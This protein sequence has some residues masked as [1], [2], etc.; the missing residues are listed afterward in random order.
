MLA[1]SN[2]LE[3]ELRITPFPAEDSRAVVMP[4][5]DFAYVS[6]F[7]DLDKGPIYI[8]GL[9]P[10]S[11]YWSVALYEANTNNYFVKNDQQFDTNELDVIITTQKHPLTK[12][13]RHLVGTL[14]PS[15]Y[16]FH[17]IKEG[18]VPI[19]TELIKSPNEKGF[20]LIRVLSTKKSKQEKDEIVKLME[21]LQVRQ[22]IR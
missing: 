5:P 6:M 16:N 2:I 3:N 9:M 10:D 14:V 12:D 13:S 20:L 7:Y 21:A 18:L 1:Q 11:T 17:L 19:G 15:Y 22:V 8:S 4:N